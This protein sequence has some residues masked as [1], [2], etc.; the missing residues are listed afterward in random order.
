MADQTIPGT[1]SVTEKVG[2][3]IEDPSA[4]LHIASPAGDP[5]EALIE[6]SG[7]SLKLAVDATG[8]SIGTTNAFPLNIQ[9]GG[10]AQ[11]TITPGGDVTVA[12]PLTV[13]SALTATGNVNIGTDATPATLE[14]KGNIQGGDATL[15]GPLTVGGNVVVTGAVNERDVS[16][17]GQKLDSHIGVT[18]GNPHGTTAAQ[19]GAL[20]L[21]GGTISGNLAVTGTV[22]G[23]DVGADGQKLDRHIGITSGN[24]HGTTAAQ[25][26]ALPLSGGTISGNLA[27]TGTVDGRD[28]SAD[29]QKLDSHIG[30]TSGNPH[31]TTAA[32]VGALPATGGTIQGNLKISGGGTAYPFQLSLGKSLGRTKLALY[33]T[34]ASNAYGLGVVSGQFRL[35]LSH[36]GARFAFF[37]SAAENAKEIVTIGGSGNLV[38]T[39]TA[40]KPGGGPWADLSDRRLKTNI[41]QLEEALETLLR[42]RGVCFEWLEPAKQ[43]NLT[44]PQIGMIAQEVETVLPDWVSTTPEGYK[45]LAIRGFEALT[46]EA[47]RELQAEHTVLQAQHDALEARVKQLEAQVRA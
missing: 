11:V 10:S 9:T 23:R 33:E 17:D 8:A 41:Q 13:Q 16:A 30:I 39:G 18:S 19:V 21:A 6:S 46:V 29:G 3:R 25:I 4:Q 35:H 12:G 27:V 37:D 40:R 14:V 7:V 47:F 44:G 45:L 24:P 38:V 20:P 34:D 26:G 32:S 42:L 36:N 28:V 2:I 43:G 5:S 22:D 15:T 31:G 1:L